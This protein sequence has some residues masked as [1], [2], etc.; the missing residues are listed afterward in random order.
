VQ[1]FF[2]RVSE[3]QRDLYMVS[4]RYGR[5]RP[6]KDYRNGYYQRDFVTKFGTLR[7]RVA[8]TRKQSFLPPVVTRFQRRAEDVSLLIRGHGCTVL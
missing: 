1:R 4:P 2:D 6:R 8:R 7:L 5:A 3:A